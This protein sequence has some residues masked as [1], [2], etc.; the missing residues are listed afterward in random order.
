M[1]RRWFINLSLTVTLLLLSGVYWFGLRQPTNEKSTTS[2]VT[3]ILG[4][5]AKGF[6]RALI[7]RTLVFPADHGAHPR[8]RHEWWYFTGNVATSDQRHFGY[9]L[10]FF[11]FGLSPTRDPTRTSNWATQQIYMAHFAMTDVTAASFYAFQRY[12]RS[13]LGLAGANSQPFKV[14]LDNWQAISSAED[15]IFPIQLR[16]ADERIGVSLQLN[17]GKELVLQGDQGLSRKG[18]Q[19]GNASHYYSYTRMPTQGHVTVDGVQYPVS[20]LSWMDREWGSG[21]L[22][23]DQVGWDWFALQLSDGRELMFYRLRHQDGSVD[24]FSGGS[25]TDIKGHTITLQH[26]EVKA[27]PM[28]YWR[29][30]TTN[31]N[32]PLQWRIEIPKQQLVLQVAP[33]VEDQELKLDVVYWEGA[34]KITGTSYRQAIGGDGYVELT[35]YAGTKGKSRGAPRANKP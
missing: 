28:R 15:G 33:Y 18:A 29:S 12:S 17:Q 11:R 2:D 19:P 16:A 9:Q 8:F 4:G 20:G 35:G 14:W 30:P 22:A 5:E 13:A 1:N 27:T 21:A 31:I 34:V 32:Y 6:D 10:T 24:V 7:P 3:S 23:K 25:L 26:D